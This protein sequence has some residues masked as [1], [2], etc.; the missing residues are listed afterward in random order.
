MQPL[1]VMYRVQ[2]DP[3]P[4]WNKLTAPQPQGPTAQVPLMTTRTHDEGLILPQAQ[5]MN[6]HEVPFSCDSLANNNLKESHSGSIPFGMNLV[7]W[8]VTNLLEVIA[9]QAPCQSD[10]FFETR[11]T[12]QDFI[13]RY[14]DDGIPYAI[15]SPFCCANTIITVRQ[16]RSTEDR[17]IGK[18][19]VPL[20]EN[21]MTRS[22]LAH[23]SSASKIAETALENRCSKLL[24]L[25]ADQRLHL[26]LHLSCLPLVFLLMCCNVVSLSSQQ[27]QSVM[28]APS[29]P[30]LC[31]RLA[32]RGAFPRFPV[33]MGSTLCAIFVSQ[34]NRA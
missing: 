6:N 20:W 9:K 8:L 31:R 2:H 10:F 12:C 16:S 26:L 23:K 7:G 30:R 33:S 18:H 22:T 32:D 15:N 1:H 14:K 29:P 24:H 4:Q 13:V 19:F 27:G 21:W 5:K 3:G 28:A 34:R 11:G 25:V 17:A